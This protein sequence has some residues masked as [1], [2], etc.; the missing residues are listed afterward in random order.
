MQLIKHGRLES[1]TSCCSR[2]CKGKTSSSLSRKRCV[3]SSKELVSTIS[4]NLS[5]NQGVLFARVNHANIQMLSAELHQRIFK[6]VNQKPKDSKTLANIEEHLT[7]HGLWN[8]TSNQNEQE[9]DFEI[10]TLQGENIAEHFEAIAKKQSR[11]YFALAEHMANSLTKIPLKPREWLMTRGWTKYKAD[12]TNVAV[13]SPDEDVLVF[14]VEV[15]MRAGNVPVL[16]T[17]VSK[18]AWYVFNMYISNLFL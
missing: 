9:I 11:R 6:G 10:P 13:E 15:C 1:V 18:T 3:T 2:F 5:T 17:A 12:G 8:K 4:R 7:K 16:A 14:D